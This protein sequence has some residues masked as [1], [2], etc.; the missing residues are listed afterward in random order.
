MLPSLRIH[1]SWILAWFHEMVSQQSGNFCEHYFIFPIKNGLQLCITKD[2]LLVIGIL[3]NNSS[4]MP[5][6]RQLYPTLK[7]DKNSRQG[8]KFHNLRHIILLLLI[9]LT[10]VMKASIICWQK[11]KITIC[12]KRWKT[13][14]NRTRWKCQQEQEEIQQWLRLL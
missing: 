9:L 4:V 6:C 8:K 1:Q 3:Q 11:K 7:K 5:F 13:D 12:E 10:N 2:L 14:G